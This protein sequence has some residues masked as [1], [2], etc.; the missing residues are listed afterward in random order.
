[1][2]FFRRYKGILSI[3]SF[4]FVG[5]P[6]WVDSMWSLSERI[7]RLQTTH[8]D[9]RWLYWITIPIGLVSL[10]IIIWQSRKKAT[11]REWEVYDRLSV[12][13][14]DLM[15]AKSEGERAEVFGHIERERGELPDTGLDTII[16]LYLDAEAE[17]TRYGV[18]PISDT[19]QKALSLCLKRMRHHFYNK[20]GIRGDGKEQ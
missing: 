11:G 6:Q 15:N 18:N 5:L 3:L 9:V 7:Q 2:E 10:I 19:S 14:R 1:M 13:L 12:S 4:L 20:Y 16:D 17:G 8:V